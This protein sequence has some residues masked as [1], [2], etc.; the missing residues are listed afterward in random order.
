MIPMKYAA[1][2]LGLAILMA[3]VV[4]AAA[5]DKT[6]PKKCYHEWRAAGYTHVAAKRGC[7]PDIGPCEWDPSAPPTPRQQA[8]AKRGLCIN[9]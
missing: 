2:I 6:D 5:A 9:E 1:P 4:A 3:S 7:R 8:N